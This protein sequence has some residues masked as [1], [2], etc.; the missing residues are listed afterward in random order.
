M[1]RELVA[2]GFQAQMLDLFSKQM[3]LWRDG[4]WWL[5]R[6]EWKTTGMDF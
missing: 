1:R 2:F 4:G 3:N 6:E 5:V